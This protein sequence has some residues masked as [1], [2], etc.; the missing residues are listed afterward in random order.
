MVL[1]QILNV[2]RFWLGCVLLYWL[3]G[4]LIARLLHLQLPYGSLTQVAIEMGFGLAFWPILLLATD[5]LG[6]HWQP[7]WARFCVLL[8][9]TASLLDLIWVPRRV[10]QQRAKFLRKRAPWLGIFGLIFALT[11]S[12]RWHH[13]RNL[14][15]PPW[16]DSV[17]HTMVA[18]LL[19]EHGALPETYAPFIPGGRFFYHWGYHA[20]VAWLAW[21]LDQTRPLEL[22]Q[23]VLHFGQVLNTLS[24]LMLYA[25]GR[26]LFNS[27]RAGLFAALIT[28]LISWFPAYYVTWGRYTQLAGL[29]ILIPFLIMLWEIKQSP[30][31]STMI[32]T[33]LLG[34]GMF[35]I[36]I[37]VFIFALTF[38]AVLTLF[39]VGEH[40]WGTLGRWILVGM[41][42]A[43]IVFPW[44]QVLLDYQK[45]QSSLLVS[46]S[47]SRIETFNEYY[48]VIQPDLLW[49]PHNRELLSLATGGLTGVLGWRAL[50]VWQR[51]LSVLWLGGL[52]YLIIRKSSVFPGRLGKALGLL[53]LWCALTALL[54]N[55][56][57]LG[58]PNLGIIHNNSAI[59]ALFIPLSLALGGL[60]AWVQ[61]ELC[62]VRWAWQTALTLVL[63]GG[64]WG[65]LT[66]RD[67]VNPTTV[68][69]KSADVEAMRWIE[70][71]TP[72]DARFAVNIWPWLGQTY[73]GSDG[74]YWI[75]LLTDRSSLLFPALYTSCLPKADVAHITETLTTWYYMNE[76]DDQMLRRWLQENRI[77]HVYIGANGGIA[78]SQRF[79]ALPFAQAIYQKN[80]VFIFEIEQP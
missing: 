5:T 74:G 61:Q 59:I 71:H 26:V 33:A 77:T 70:T 18:R 28:G 44:L 27:R 43:V 67:V 4:R 20:L 54:L 7:T 25:A 75:P 57:L 23:L 68:L 72:P 56:H 35:L 12:T 76:M 38:I 8:I 21:F 19:A 46:N 45:I 3:A 51:A 24:V 36:H 47:P 29:L 6:L 11:L 32:A 39:I 9:G 60:F 16:I 64:L 65:A 73:A 69:A 58:M 50:P 2:G 48:N 15:L 79:L 10:W 13:I 55:V 34:A 66:I 22:A 41:I 14:A 62:P 80:E 37:R 63:I 17:H 78:S 42:I 31:R 52:V 40:D 30:Y 49:A 53:I 1:P